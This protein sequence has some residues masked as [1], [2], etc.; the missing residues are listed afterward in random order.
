MPGSDDMVSLMVS[1]SL[2]IVGDL[3]ALN[4]ISQDCGLGMEYNARSEIDIP[5]LRTCAG[6]CL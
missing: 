3:L 4:L 6:L 5:M 2:H 1:H